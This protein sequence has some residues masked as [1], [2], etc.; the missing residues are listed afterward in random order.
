MKPQTYCRCKHALMSTV[1]RRFPD[2]KLFNVSESQAM[3]RKSQADLR[4]TEILRIDSLIAV[5]STSPRSLS[6]R[7]MAVP[8]NMSDTI[9]EG[10]ITY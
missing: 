9:L 1:V 6:Q 4:C 8:R 3:L 7:N 10:G 5:C 2:T